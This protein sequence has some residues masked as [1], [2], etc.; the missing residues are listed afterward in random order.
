M[1]TALTLAGIALAAYA[2]IV[3]FF[4]LR[5][6]ALL[7]PASSQRTSAAQAG[8]SGF[9]DV[10]LETPDGERIVGWY[11]APEPGRAVLIYF[12]GNGGSL[13]NRAGRARLLTQDGRGLLI[14]SYR[15]YSGSTGSPTEPGLRIDARAAYDW[16]A[17]RH[18]AER[19]V[20]YGESLGSGVAVGL[21]AERRVAG[22][23]LDAPFTSAADVAGH[24]FRFLP[25]WLLRDQYRSLDRIRDVGAPLLVLHGDRDGVVPYA[26]GERL[27]EH[28]HEPKRHLRITGGDHVSNLE[29]GGLAAVRAFLSEVEMKVPP[30]P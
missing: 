24:H 22:L 23:V 2:A 18:P 12:H 17:R 1:R 14:V 26:L 9:E 3:L 20:L 27:Y 21:A 19:I 16:L 28:A 29:A 4:Y 6:A 5:Q 25:V 30:A 10:V 11:K 13:L 15:G 8:L 7:Y